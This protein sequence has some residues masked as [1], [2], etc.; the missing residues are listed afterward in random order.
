M[1]F[2]NCG[3]GAFGEVSVVCSFVLMILTRRWQVLNQSYHE[4]RVDMGANSSGEWGLSQT[5]NL[6]PELG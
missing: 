1:R 3:W 5:H 6:P 4:L 2:H